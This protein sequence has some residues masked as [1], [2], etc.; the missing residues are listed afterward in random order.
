MA[1]LLLLARVTGAALVVNLGVLI[2]RQ[3]S[4]AGD[5]IPLNLSKPC[6]DCRFAFSIRRVIGSIHLPMHSVRAI[7]A[8]RCCGLMPEH[9]RAPG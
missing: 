1:M 2:L 8:K 6:A 5:S 9:G 7:V 4:P 3:D